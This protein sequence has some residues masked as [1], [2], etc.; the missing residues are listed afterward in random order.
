VKKAIFLVLVGIFAL[1][2]FSSCGTREEGKVVARVGDRE[3]STE[4]LENEW[5]QASRIKIRGISE[6]QRKKELVDKLV[7][8]QVVIMEAY[9]EGLDN[10]VEG[11]SGFVGQK[12]R[13]ILNVL[14]QREIVDKSQPTESEMRKEYDRMK[15]EVRAS[16]ILVETEEE[17]DQIYQEVKAGADFSELAK[18]KSIDPTAKD[19]GGDLGFFTWGKMVGEFQE[20]AFALKEGEISKPIKTTYGWHVI[21][22][23]ERKEKEQP[24]YEESK[25]LIESKLVQTKREERVK[26]YFAELRKK[27]GFK[28][29]QEAYD[30]LLS[31]KEEVP[32]DTLGLK[33]PGDVL[34]MSKLTMEERDMA[35]CTYSDGAI[36]IVQFAEQFNNMPQ[37]YRPR[38]H[39]REKVEETAFGSL[40]Q[41]LLLDVAKKQNIEESKEF[42]KQWDVVKEREMAKRM[43]SDVI[44]K[45]VGISDEEIESYYQ[46]HV[47]RFTVQPQ[48]NVREILVKTE[49]E[50]Q[51]L[52]KQLRGGADFSKLAMDNTIRTYAKGSGGLL[53]SFPRTRYPEIFDAAQEMKTGSLGGPLKIN[54]RQFGETYSV[55]K[56]EEKT[57]GKVQP[58]EEVKERVTSM[59]RREKDQTIFQN[60]VQNAKARYKIEIFDQVIESTVAEV[61]KAPTEEG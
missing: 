3:I 38:L 10:E 47:D 56:L 19:N 52:L 59:A 9:K 60:W 13:L 14:Y 55:I 29:N 32:P 49:E 12:E 22:L 53:G 28:I 48:V 21:K 41:G 46:R 51:G 57:E 11:D 26:E 39:E 35:L 43:T 58:L 5:K 2:L 27:V 37:A 4:D 8:D 42:K 34:D 18:E 16:H 44:L 17:A 1:A 23:V 36:S 40:V 45:G 15:V 24:P 25:R 30:L 31:K 7:G 6:L 61:E 20:A 54:D 50:A 33:R